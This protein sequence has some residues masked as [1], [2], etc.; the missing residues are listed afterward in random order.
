MPQLIGD[1]L[2]FLYS[3]DPLR[4]L[5]GSGAVLLEQPAAVAAENFHWGS[6]A[7]PFDD[8]WLMVIRESE[9]MGERRNHFHRFV[10]LDSHDRLARLSR[11]FF[12]QRMADEFVAGLAWHVTDEH[13]V[14]SFGIADRE[15]MVAVVRVA[16]V[17]VAL[18]TV[19]DHKNQSD[20]ACEAGHRAWQ[21]MRETGE[22]STTREASSIPATVGQAGT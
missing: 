3:M 12:F 11:R 15:P 13:L 16:D 8:G 1:E 17:R 14:I 4:I 18:L 21:A 5:G 10:W 22:R 2:R 7:I 9:L 6:Q 20:R 19:E